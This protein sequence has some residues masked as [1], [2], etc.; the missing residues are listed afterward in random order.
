MTKAL[1]NLGQQEAIFVGEGAS[2]PARIRIQDLTDD[3]LP[4][5]QTAKFAKGWSLQR[6]TEEEIKIVAQRMAS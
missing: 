2:L 5:S 3:K 6:L 4:K 1:P